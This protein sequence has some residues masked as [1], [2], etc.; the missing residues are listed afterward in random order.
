MG[1]MKRK[2]INKWLEN[3]ESVFVTFLEGGLCGKAELYDVDDQWNKCCF[4]SEGALHITSSKSD[5]YEKDKS[6]PRT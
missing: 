6:L 5:L 4:Q 2:L 1:F 3:I